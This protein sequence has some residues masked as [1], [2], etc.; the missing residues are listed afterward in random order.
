MSNLISTLA[1]VPGQEHTP[2]STAPTSAFAHASILQIVFSFAGMLGMGLVG[3]VFYTL[4]A[5]PVDGDL[6]WHIKVGRSILQT[7]HFPTAESYSFTAGGQHWRAY[8]WL[9][10]VLLAAIYQAGG[11]RGL[12][13][14]LIVLGSVIALALYYYTTLRCGN[15]KAGFLATALLLNLATSFNLRPQM[16]GY[17]F[18]ILTLIILERFRQGKRGAVWLLPLLM[19]MWINTHGLWII[20][21]GTIGVYLASGLMS[22]RIGNVETQRWTAAERGQLTAVFLLSAVAT[23]ITPYG[24]GLATYPF[25]MSASPVGL[26]NISE[27]QAI[28]FYLSGDMLFLGLV[29]GFLLVQILMRPRWRLEELGLF[30]FGAMMAFLHARFLSLFVAFSA[31]VLVVIFAR[32]LPKYDRAKEVYALNTA[33]IL[34]IVGAMAWYFPTSGDYSRIVEKKF[35]IAAVQYL[36]THSVPGP[37]YNSNEFGGYL[38]WARGPEHKVFIDGRSEIYEPAGIL[39][40]QVALMNLN[41]GSLAVLQKYNIQSCLLWRDEALATGLAALPEWKRVYEDDTTVLFTRQQSTVE[42]DTRVTAE[43]F[44]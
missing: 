5:F 2:D 11:L 28:T 40:D 27:W 7:H 8:E 29:I 6:W 37:M 38:L 32:W 3:K 30:L 23:L 33:I 34:G 15:P 44:D 24:A 22:I 1:E 39:S 17:L 25:Q 10:E 9:G 35:P 20:G 16:L 36:N 13:T 41:H 21:L 42:P 14:L 18:L 26:A 4:R 19:L 12:G 43:A 31:P